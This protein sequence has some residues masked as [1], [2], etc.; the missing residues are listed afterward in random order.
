MAGIKI[1]H[2]EAD[3]YDLTFNVKQVEEYKTYK[4]M[5]YSAAILKD[6]FF[7]LAGERINDNMTDTH[8]ASGIM[9]YDRLS[10]GGS[11]YVAGGL[12]NLDLLTVGTRHRF[13]MYL[14]QNNTLI[15]GNADEPSFYSINTPIIQFKGV[16]QQQRSDLSSFVFYG[17]SK[18]LLSFSN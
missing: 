14:S 9:Y 1:I 17:N 15:I 8:D 7:L 16:S 10:N 12:T 4:N 6:T 18:L 2:F 3:L 5:E 13:S 11:G